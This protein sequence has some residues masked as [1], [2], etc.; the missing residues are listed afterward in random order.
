MYA[1]VANGANLPRWASGLGEAVCEDAGGWI[2]DGPLG[3]VRVEF[4][5]PDNALGVLD[6]RCRAGDP[7]SRVR[8]PMRVVANGAGSA[9]IFTL[10][11][12]Y[13]A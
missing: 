11:C 12:G 5:A 8:N 9:V 2:A 1:F 7:E 3:R 10:R 13:R 6:H 4:V